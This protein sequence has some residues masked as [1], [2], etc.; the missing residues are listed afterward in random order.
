MAGAVIAGW[1]VWNQ[2][3][4]EAPDD[5]N[6]M[7]AVTATRE[8]VDEH[9]AFLYVDVML[10]NVGKV[11]VKP[12]VFREGEGLELTLREFTRDIA[13][14][15]LLKDA[16]QVLLYAPEKTDDPMWSTAMPP[17]NII[18]HYESYKRGDYVLM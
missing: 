11:S 1:W 14:P 5:P 13:T 18:E 10:K 8:D 2:F 3:Y 9:M 16:H 15:G 6:I 12:G 4:V 17:T 7:V